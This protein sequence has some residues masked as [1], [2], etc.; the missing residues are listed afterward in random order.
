MPGCPRPL[1]RWIVSLTGV[2]ALTAC[3]GGS[4]PHPHVTA[5][6]P[7]Q[8]TVDH[9]FCI[10]T[11]G[12][13]A[14]NVCDA[15]ARFQPDRA[16]LYKVLGSPNPQDQRAKDDVLEDLRVVA[17]TNPDPRR[18]RQDTPAFQ[19]IT[20]HVLNNPHWSAN[21][22]FVDVH[23][24]VFGDGGSKPIEV[25]FVSPPAGQRQSIEAQIRLREQWQVWRCTQPLSQNNGNCGQRPLLLYSDPPHP[26][27]HAGLG[28]AAKLY[29]FRRI[30]GK[31]GNPWVVY[32]IF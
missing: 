23:H 12:P 14:A 19:K 6:P 11:F 7:P 28:I 2:A 16:Q 8:I 15:L 10:R 27:P 31:S 1:R 21:P 9:G 22:D 26:N 5:S 32:D 29:T 20:G 3:G 4:A 13:E 18:P 25:V 24:A 17:N 30:P